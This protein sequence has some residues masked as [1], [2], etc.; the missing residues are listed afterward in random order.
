MEATWPGVTLK[1]KYRL[2]REWLESSLEEKDLGVPVDEKLNVSRQCVLT[3]Q[4]ANRIL[5]CINRSAAS[6][7]KEGILTLYSAL[8]PGVLRPALEPP[9]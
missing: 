8:P 5:G 1:H 9:V 4:K 3:A 7:S 2:G 6:R